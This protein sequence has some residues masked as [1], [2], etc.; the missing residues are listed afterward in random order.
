MKN[1]LDKPKK[2]FSPPV[3]AVITK[4]KSA[5][6]VA[7]DTSRPK[8]FQITAVIT[9]IQKATKQ[10]QFS[11]R[12]N[13]VSAPHS[14]LPTDVTDSGSYND[15]SIAPLPAFR[16]M[17]PVVTVPGAIFPFRQESL[18]SHGNGQRRLEP[19][20]RLPDSAPVP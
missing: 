19:R 5:S 14:V 11:R 9:R 13:D 3:A 17:R 15:R 4:C 2:I 20:Q 18:D 1:R 8:R 10:H 16:L 12:G 7:Q 6:G